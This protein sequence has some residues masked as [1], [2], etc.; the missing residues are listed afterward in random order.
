VL[1][2]ILLPY[3]NPDKD[4]T[5]EII[6]KLGLSKSI[7]QNCSSLSGGE[8]QRV[9]F[10]RVIYSLKPIVLLDEITSNLDP[11]S[12][13]IIL[14]IIEEISSTHLVI[15]V[16]HENLPND[17]I[18][19]SS[20]L[21]LQDG[22]LKTMKQEENKASIPVEAERLSNRKSNVDIKYSF[23]QEKKSH[24]WLYL[25]STIF[26]AFSIIFL[27]MGFTFEQKYDDK[28]QEFISNGYNDKI[29]EVYSKTTPVFLSNSKD[30]EGTPYECYD[31]SLKP[32]YNNEEKYGNP[33][34]IFSGFFYYSENSSLPYQT[35]IVSG[36]KPLKENEV[37]ISDVCFN[38]C[39][40]GFSIGDKFPDNDSLTVV[41][42]YKALDLANFST[43]Y[44]CY[45]ENDD[46]INQTVRISYGFMSESVFT[47]K[48]ESASSKTFAY[49]NTTGNEKTFL[50]KKKPVSLIGLLQLLSIRME[51]LFLPILVIL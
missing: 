34:T 7:N 16:T 43:R 42:T 41:G 27:S 49:P 12:S 40:K 18:K 9:S 5:K 22:S 23:K 21:L 17:F 26:V 37:I 44:L 35:E 10:G 39:T 20:L 11:E 24:I 38:N 1:E 6:S 32:N 2:N 4:R 48:K 25:I 19:D 33:G 15:F 31:S 45:N 13:S 3:S 47:Y 50:K 46:V 51:N 14:Q 36:R 30:Y 28:K 29:T 8:K